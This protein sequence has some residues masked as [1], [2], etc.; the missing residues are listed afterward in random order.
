MNQGNIN[1]RSRLWKIP[2]HWEQRRGSWLQ[3]QGLINSWN[4]GEHRKTGNK[5]D[6]W[7]GTVKIKQ[8][9]AKLKPQNVTFGLEKAGKDLELSQ[10]PG[11]SPIPWNTPTTT[12]FL[13]TF[14]R[15][16]LMFERRDSN[17]KSELNMSHWR[18]Y[19]DSWSFSESSTGDILRSREIYIKKTDVW[20]FLIRWQNAHMF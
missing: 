1:R 19:T 17:W 8:D 16:K 9:I 20:R 5:D 6:I 2:K 14:F 3:T 18:I 13:S 12:T 15:E 7:E 10:S 4:T 11:I